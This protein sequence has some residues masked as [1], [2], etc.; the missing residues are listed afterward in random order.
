MLAGGTK[1][2]EAS[3]F[4]IKLTLS[5]LKKF[6]KIFS[7]NRETFVLRI[8]LRLGKLKQTLRKLMYKRKEQVM[9]KLIAA[10]VIAIS[11]L[12]TGIAFASDN[13]CQEDQLDVA[14]N[15][16]KSKQYYRTGT[17][18]RRGRKQRGQ[19][20]SKLNLT[21]NQ[22]DQL[23]RIWSEHHKSTE[24]QRAELQ[25][26]MLELRKLRQADKL[27]FRAV[28]A[29]KKKVSNQKVQ[30]QMANLRTQEKALSVLTPQQQQTLKQFRAQR[31][32]QMRSG[33]YRTGTRYHRARVRTNCVRC[34]KAR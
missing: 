33:R 1:T 12:F 6:F 26:S 7:P 31:Q 23:A 9:K 21:Q 27:N 16:V 28:E 34:I 19:L 18:T 3:N 32:S 29:Q 30:L 13:C 24:K 22:K 5:N 10:L 2:A 20:A 17:R 14:C 25:K 11:L 8:Y 15:R 4:Q